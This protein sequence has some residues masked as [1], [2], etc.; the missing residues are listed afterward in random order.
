MSF[1]L[2]L[3]YVILLLLLRWTGGASGICGVSKFCFLVR[4]LKGHCVRRCAGRSMQRRA[5]LRG[6]N[7]LNFSTSFGLHCTGRT[8]RVLHKTSSEELPGLKWQCISESE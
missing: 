7:A 6:L 1:S 2:E 5:H 8:A 3:L 4:I